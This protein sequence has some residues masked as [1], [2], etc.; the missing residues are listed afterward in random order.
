MSSL[1][2]NTVCG[3]I[4]S[5]ELGMTLVHEHFVAAIPGWETDVTLYP[6][7]RKDAVAAGLEMAE[8]VKA[9]GV[10]TIVDPI[11]MDFGRM[12]EI[13]KEVSE[14]SGLNIICSTGYYH[15]AG[16]T[17]G[18]WT[19]RSF[20]ADI[21]PELTEVFVQEIEEGI[22]STGIRAGVI[23][24]ASG[25]GV[26]SGYE[27]KMFRA[28]AAAQKATGVPI[29]THT[30]NGTM[31]PEQAELLIS[32]G[33][34]PGKIMIGHT[35]DNTDI[36][37]HLRILRNG[38]FDSFDRMGM[39]P[40]DEEKYPVIA[41]LIEKGYVEKLMLSHDSVA[42]FPG[43]PSMKLFPMLENSYPTYVFEKVIPALK[44]IGVTDSQV[45]TLLETNPRRLFE[46]DT[47]S[48]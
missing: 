20:I 17:P 12:P 39:G 23:K 35:S 21:I 31:G 41:E 42:F 16:G 7:D 45:T 1:Q 10:N 4:E 29:V 38:V 3:T 11:P 27:R 9:H 36:D 22:G 8:N 26:I 30:Q 14:S 44:E 47:N 40:P 34:P 15:E 33:V 37:Y 2:V 5:D 19:T 46:N 24:V 43:R 13:C 6:L 48:P 32:E 28:A 18:Y 25:D